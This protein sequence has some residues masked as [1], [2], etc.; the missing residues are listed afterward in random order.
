[1]KQLFLLLTFFSA[2]PVYPQQPKLMLPVGHS[3]SVKSAK[4]SADG[5]YVV[6]ASY[7]MVKIWET[8]TGRL[9]GNLFHP[10]D[11]QT[12]Q[13]SPD[14]KYILT[15]SDDNTTKIWETASGK[16]VKVLKGITRR[17]QIGNG[18]I[19]ISAAFSSNGHYILTCSD[20]IN[21]MG[22]ARIWVTKTGKLVR[23]I[24]FDPN[25]HGSTIFSP[26]GRDVLT[27]SKILS[28]ASINISQACIW[29]FLTG[30]LVK[31]FKQTDEAISSVAYSKDGSMIATTSE[32]SRTKIWDVKTGVLL[33]FFSD[34]S[35]K[36]ESAAFSPDG[37][38]LITMSWEG[39]VYVHDVKKVSQGKIGRA[40]V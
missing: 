12:V 28:G 24:R 14:S 16:L 33:M 17:D 31:R 1:M 3:T 34:D 19:S 23:N 21:D 27:V 39:D 9:L 15:A 13:F 29:N 22:I 5:K 7:G 40:H 2:I 4:F 38:K 32:K 18:G 6:T 36:I 20:A 37:T 8:N 25:Y 10:A 11:I 30:T 26:N 35:S